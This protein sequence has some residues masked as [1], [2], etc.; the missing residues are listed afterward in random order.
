MPEI[1][2]PQSTRTIL[3]FARKSNDGPSFPPYPKQIS[4]QATI[5]GVRWHLS[6]LDRLGQGGVLLSRGLGRL[7]VLG[8]GV[9]VVLLA[10]A[11]NGDLDGD[12]ATVDL[13]AVHL[14]DGLGLELL[15]GHGHESKATGLAA[16]VAGLE[17]LDHETGNGTESHLGRNG[18]VLGEDFLE[19][20]NP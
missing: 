4:K 2:S 19:L 3:R 12:G 10:R 6:S 13:L 14:V 20:M 11:V 9:D 5:E 17:L 15:R 16:L 18:G 8:G 7:V 1:M